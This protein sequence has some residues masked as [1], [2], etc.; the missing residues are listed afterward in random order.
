LGGL[1]YLVD[2]RLIFVP[3][4][5]L[6][7]LLSALRIAIPTQLIEQTVEAT[8]GLHSVDKSLPAKPQ[9][10]CQHLNVFL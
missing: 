7:I 2:R 3:F 6:L 9:D 10:E 8:P 1:Q 4:P 5:V